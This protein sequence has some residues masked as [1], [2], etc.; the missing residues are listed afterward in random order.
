MDKPYI[1]VIIPVYNA[2]KY[3]EQTLS[4]LL[5]QTF[6]NFEVICVNDCSKDNSLALLKAFEEKD[7]R[8]KCIDLKAN[9]GAGQARN[10]GIGAANG[11]YIAFIDADDAV[12]PDMF[13]KALAATDGGRISQVVW[14]AVEE[15]Y[16]ADGKLVRS[17]PI[18]PQKCVCT[19]KKD[20]A[21]AALQL[22]NQTLFGYLW[23]SIYKTDIIKK[24]NLRMRDSI[25][26]EDYFFNLDFLKAS[27]SLAVIDYIGY[28]YYKRDNASITHSFSKEYFP[29]SYERIESFYNYCAE[30]GILSQNA[31]EILGNRLLRYTLSALARNNNPLSETDAKGRREQIAYMI[32]LPLY[33]TVLTEDFN[34]NPIFKIL[35]RLILKGRIGLL[36]LIGKAVYILKK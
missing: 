32:N 11:E 4:S 19:E 14:G 13:E 25:F 23:N 28:H 34:S 36:S 31:F 22:E 12:E 21:E 8:I 7:A 5:K 26:Y 1:S 2:E 27:D 6:Q 30:N 18:I 15:Y 16:N 3:I 17:V 24:N 35:K 10:Y 20:I 33:N 29:L 9:S